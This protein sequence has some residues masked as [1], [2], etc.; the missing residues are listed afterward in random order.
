MP[1]LKNYDNPCEWLLDLLLWIEFN[2]TAVVVLL[3]LFSAIAYAER[4]PWTEMSN[5]VQGD[6]LYI[7]GLSSENRLLEDGREKALQNAL[8]ELNNSIQSEFDGELITQRT[9]QELNNGSW[10]VWR[11]MYVETSEIKQKR[12]SKHTEVLSEAGKN[13]YFYTSPFFR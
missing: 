12:F 9:Y 8:R 2:S 13:T 11:L 1:L 3:C 4:P 5:F 10:T 7:V 6:R